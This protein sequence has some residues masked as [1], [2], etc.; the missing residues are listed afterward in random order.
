MKDKKIPSKPDFN[1]IKKNNNSKALL[2]LL[3]ISLIIALLLPY[4]KQKET[5]KDT[6]IAL[7]QLE[8][9]YLD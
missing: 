2:T 9:K 5:Y 1:N 6:D 3:V 4:I 7:N 8:Q